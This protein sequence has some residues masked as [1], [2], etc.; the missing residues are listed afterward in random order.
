MVAKEK[1]LEPLKDLLVDVLSR[2]E[3]LEAKAGVTPPPAATRASPTPQPS[4]AS[5][6]GTY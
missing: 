2:L 3:A 4:Q 5:L 6:T 1:A